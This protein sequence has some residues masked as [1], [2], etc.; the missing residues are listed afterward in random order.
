MK[1][2]ELVDRSGVSSATIKYYV[3]EGLLMPGERV[4]G[5]RTEYAEEHLQRLRLIR[6]MLEVGKLS[7]ESVS[8]VLGAL[9]AVDVPLS[10]TFEIA[11]RSLARSAV[12]EKSEPSTE[13]LARVDALR[14]RTRGWEPI[15]DNIGQRVTAEAI[16][17]FAAAGYPVSDDYLDSYAVAAQ[18]AATADLDIVE[19]QEQRSHKAEVMIV[20]S[21]FGD[22]LALG[23]R[24]IAQAAVSFERD[25]S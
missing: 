24:R 7:I 9:E 25:S 1:I 10:H 4:G 8:Q 23:L 5:N 18:R 13:A 3:R 20:G 19:A 6:A 16:D 15:V 21:V 14:S 22:S 11:Q 17:A 2:S 12:S